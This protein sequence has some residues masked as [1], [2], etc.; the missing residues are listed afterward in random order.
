[1]YY[2]YYRIHT[3]I[4]RH[5]MHSML[6]RNNKYIKF[7]VLKCISRKICQL[8]SLTGLHLNNISKTYCV[9]PVTQK[10][11]V[12]LYFV[13]FDGSFFKDIFNTFPALYGGM[14]ISL[15]EDAIFP[16]I[17]CKPQKDVF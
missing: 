7:K 12:L 6:N 3:L 11:K 2:A 13:G 14:N 16:A 4:I 15:S 9:Y 1:M 17:F 8:F 5:S 10:S